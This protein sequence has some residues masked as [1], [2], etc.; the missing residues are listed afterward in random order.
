MFCTPCCMWIFPLSYILDFRKLQ[1]YALRGWM[2]YMAFLE[3]SNFLWRTFITLFIKCWLPRLGQTILERLLSTHQKWKKAEPEYWVSHQI[4]LKAI[5][6][7]TYW[8]TARRAR[9]KECS[10][11][12]PAINNFMGFIFMTVFVMAFWR[13][14]VWLAK[15]CNHG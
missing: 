3:E 7:L 6:S 1:L 4:L 15:S 8:T 14:K 10:L 5:I 2:E 13:K 12:I 11:K 9:T